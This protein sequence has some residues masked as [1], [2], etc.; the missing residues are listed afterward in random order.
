VATLTPGKPFTVAEPRLL[1]ENQ[2]APG[3][4]RFQ[5]VV[6]D[7]GG[8]ES[9]PAELVV[10]VHDVVRPT[11]PT[12]PTRPDIVEIDPD[13]LGRFRPRRP[14]LTEIRPDIIRPIRP[15]RRPP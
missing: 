9:D 7:D 15:I 13:I 10:A 11:R 6:V 14:D 3:R 12:R 8:L 1:V 2:F 5:L 4:Y